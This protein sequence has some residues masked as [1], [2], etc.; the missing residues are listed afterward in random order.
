M[1]RNEEE[2]EMSEFEFKVGDKVKCAFFGDK[3]FT[4]AKNQGGYLCIE[5]K[6]N[7]VSFYRDGRESENHTHPVLTFVERPKTKVKV[8]RWMNIYPQWT[9]CNFLDKQAA[10]TNAKDSRIACVELKGEYEI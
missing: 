3:I 4:L 6:N 1:N 10:D 9:S 8:V 5:H 7:Y 2:I